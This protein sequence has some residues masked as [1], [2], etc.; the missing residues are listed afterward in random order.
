MALG[1]LPGLNFFGD[2]IFGSIS[3]PAKLSLD[4]SQP[5]A[6]WLS[7]EEIKPDWG[8][9]RRPRG[10][11]LGCPDNGITCPEDVL[12]LGQWPRSFPGFSPHSSWW[13]DCFWGLGSRHA[14][15]T[16]PRM[17]NPSPGRQAGSGDSQYQ[18]RSPPLGRRTRLA[19]PGGDKGRAHSCRLP[20]PPAWSSGQFTEMLYPGCREHSK[21]QDGV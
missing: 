7:P 15:V 6:T 14:R 19:L 8:A 13:N 5:S 10:D 9:G 18:L 4:I 2:P 17:Q 12:S 20:L 21:E 3:T 1:A 16:W 11:G